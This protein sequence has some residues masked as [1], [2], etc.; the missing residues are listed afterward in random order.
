MNNLP[1]IVSFS[2]GLS[3]GKML[4]DLIEANPDFREKYIV[5]FENT[6]KEHDATLDFVRDFAAH[7]RI[8]IVWLEYCRVPAIEVPL[9]MV[10]EGGARTNMAKRQERG[11]KTHWFREVTYETAARTNDKWTP[12]D[13]LLEWASVLPNVRSRL[14]SVQMKVRTRDRWAYAQG[15][16]DFNSFIGIRADEAHRVEEIL[17]NIGKFEKP[18]FPMVGAG[19]TRHDVNTH[20]AA[21]PFTLNIP[22]RMGNCGGCYLKAKWKRILI[23]REHPETAQWWLN[24]ET[25][26]GLTT[27]GDGGKF[28]RRMSW[29]QIIAL[30]ND[31][32]FQIREDEEDVACS[33]AI[34]GYRGA[35]ANDDDQLEFTLLPDEPAA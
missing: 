21:Q 15:I 17:A 4:A 34:G 14:C 20:W 25:K 10:K 32:T 27:H 5:V 9:E 12:F 3:S 24:W 29:A 35:A 22:N 18:L 7:H 31:P 16:R 28:D 8:K 2:G 33:C 23:A 6:G 1:N 11:E 19:I 30:A 13:E 26:R